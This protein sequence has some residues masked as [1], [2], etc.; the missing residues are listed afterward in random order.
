MFKKKKKTLIVQSCFKC[1]H[2]EYVSLGDF[3]CTKHNKVVIRQLD[4]PT[5]KFMCC[6][7]E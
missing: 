6:K 7:G 4:E 3:I 1:K 2:C 5:N